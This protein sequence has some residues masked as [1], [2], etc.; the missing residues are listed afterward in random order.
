MPTFSY[1]ELNSDTGTATANGLRNVAN[2]AANFVCD[3]WQN[4]TDVAAGLPDPTGLGAALNGLYSNLC[5]PRGKQP[6]R[7]P[8]PAII[9]G[10][11]PGLPYN[12][13]VAY[14]RNGVPQ[15]SVFF[16]SV[17]GPL[18]GVG[19]VGF[20]TGSAAYGVLA[21]NATASGGI[22]SVVSAGGANPQEALKDYQITNVTVTPVGHSDQCGNSS[23][24]Y[25][26]PVPP[27][28]ATRKPNN[29][30]NIGG[31]LII[32][33]PITLIPTL[34]K[35]DVDITPQLNVQVGPFN[36]T[37]DLGGVYIKPDFKLPQDKILPP[38]IYLP[39]PKPAP[40]Q[41]VNVE[42]PD[43][44]L[45]PV[46]NRLI[47]L[48]SDVEDLIET[49]EDIKDCSCP[50]PYDLVVTDLGVTEGDIFVLP[51][52]A[53]SI[54]VYMLSAPKN[55][56][57]Q[58]GRGGHPDQYFWGYY[59]FGDGVA[60]SERIPL[61]TETGWFPVPPFATTFAINLYLGY[62]ARVEVVSAVPEK[63][64]EFAG[65]QMKLKP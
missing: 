49:A 23:P 32:A 7:S 39:E 65:R 35:A 62:T 20:Q 13:T 33:A 16:P 55:P 29:T 37:F 8:A 42:C 22:L 25:N 1:Q 2:Q 46:V 5:S 4:Y 15:G 47:N 19:V 6:T 38:S 24:Q 21:P 9:G 60:L 3:L 27:G 51:P 18:T 57:F 63:P 48:Q 11:C 59:E 30:V 14:S 44:D 10:Q 45:S 28:S 41:P 26:T 50:V 56:K 53:E 40:K 34:F 54:R 31:G 43:I 12:V 61:N 52:S 64:A 58:V 36:V 17:P